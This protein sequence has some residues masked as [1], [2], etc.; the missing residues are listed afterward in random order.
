MMKILKMKLVKNE[1]KVDDEV[2]KVDLKK[3]KN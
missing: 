3:L 2:V 1:D